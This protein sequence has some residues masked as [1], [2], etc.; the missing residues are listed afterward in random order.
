MQWEQLSTD[1]LKPY[2]IFYFHLQASICLYEGHFNTTQDGKS[3]FLP[4]QHMYETYM[5]QIFCTY[6]I[7]GHVTCK[8]KK[9]MTYTTL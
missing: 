9:K 3:Y 2:P 7:Q 5:K 8:K 4:S 1:I 6:G